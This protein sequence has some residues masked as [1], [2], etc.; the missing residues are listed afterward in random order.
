MSEDYDYDHAQ[1]QCPA[2]ACSLIL[3]VSRIRAIAILK[4]KM[5]SLAVAEK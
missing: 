4:R 3:Q 2:I 1:L 5:R